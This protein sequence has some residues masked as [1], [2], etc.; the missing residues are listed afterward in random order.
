MRLQ[1]EVHEHC[2]DRRRV[3]ADP[4]GAAGLAQGCVL[5]PIECALA[6]QGR[7]VRPARLQLAGEHRQH[8]I[9]PQGVVVEQVLVAEGKAKDA[10][11]DQRSDLVLDPLRSAGVA[12]A[13]GEAPDQVDG[14]VRRAEQQRTGV[15][16]DRPAVEAS[17]HRAPLNGC[18]RKQ[19]RATLCAHRGVLRIAV[20]STL[21][22]QAAWQR[23]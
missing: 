7:A 11:T 5:E 17:D 14:A 20:S 9:M 16:G 6:G 8:R 3:V 1:E 21:A 12:E 23:A 19:R 4:V 2:L 15:G 10:L 22:I 13:G 18:K